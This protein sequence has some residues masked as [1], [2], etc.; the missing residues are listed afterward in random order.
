MVTPPNK[1]MPQFIVLGSTGVARGKNEK[2]K[3]GRRKSRAQ[4]LTAKP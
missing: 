3:M 1:T 2:T 4:T